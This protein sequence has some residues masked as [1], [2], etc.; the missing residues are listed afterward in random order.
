MQLRDNTKST[1]NPRE[2]ISSYFE[3]EDC[4]AKLCDPIQLKRCYLEN[5]FLFFIMKLSTTVQ[6]GSQQILHI[7]EEAE[8]KCLHEHRARVFQYQDTLIKFI[9]QPLRIYR[10]NEISLT[11]PRS[12]LYIEE[13]ERVFLEGLFVS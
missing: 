9:V 2:H 8:G 3:C 7:P 6:S 4:Q 1:L 11:D 12:K 5:S 10:L 13:L